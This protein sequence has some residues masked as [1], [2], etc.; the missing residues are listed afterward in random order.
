[1]SRETSNEKSKRVKIKTY[2][3][4][5]LKNIFLSINGLIQ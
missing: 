5:K 2:L 1:M 3:L 4:K